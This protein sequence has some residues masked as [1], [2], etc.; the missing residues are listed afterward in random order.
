MSAWRWSLPRFAKDVR[1]RS[2]GNGRTQLIWVE[3][4]T[5]FESA[6]GIG[7]PIVYFEDKEATYAG[8]DNTQSNTKDEANTPAEV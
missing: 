7:L 2:L 8:Q 5:S 6:I 3:G 1:I 4:T